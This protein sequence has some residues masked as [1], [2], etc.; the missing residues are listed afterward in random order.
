[1]LL[2]PGEHDE[3]EGC[4]WFLCFFLC[5]F[6]VYSTRRRRQSAGKKKTN[7]KSQRSAHNAR[8]AY[9]QRCIGNG[10]RYLRVTRAHAAAQLSSLT[11][12]IY[13]DNVRARYGLPIATYVGVIFLIAGVRFVV[14][15]RDAAVPISCPA[16]ASSWSRRRRCCRHC[17]RRVRREDERRNDEPPRSYSGK[18]TGTGALRRGD[19]SAGGARARK[20]LPATAEKIDRNGRTANPC[21]TQRVVGAGRRQCRAGATGSRPACRDRESPSTAP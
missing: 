6:M 18:E 1:M 4:F 13:P 5:F 11:D 14:D 7:E 3:S 17:R 21:G 16:G 9:I 2:Q 10:N 12:D 19:A 15:A 20:Y 8:G